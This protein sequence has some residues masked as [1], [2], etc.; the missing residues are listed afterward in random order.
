MAGRKYVRPYD[1]TEDNKAV[2]RDYLNELENETKHGFEQN[3]QCVV[4]GPSSALPKANRRCKTS[5]P[6]NDLFD[7]EE[8]ILS[9]GV[10]CIQFEI[11]TCEN[12]E[13]TPSPKCYQKLSFVVPSELTKLYMA[14]SSL[15]SEPSQYAWLRLFIKEIVECQEFGLTYDET[16][17]EHHDSAFAKSY[18]IVMLNDIFETDDWDARRRFLIS[19]YSKQRDACNVAF[20]AECINTWNRVSAIANDIDRGFHK[21][22][23]IITNLDPKKFEPMVY[24]GFYQICSNIST[25]WVSCCLD[26]SESFYESLSDFDYARVQLRKY[27][28]RFVT[29]FDILTYEQIGILD[30]VLA[31][32]VKKIHTTIEHVPV[33]KV[34]PNKRSR[35]SSS[36][37]S[38]ICASKR[39]RANQ[40]ES[41]EDSNE[42]DDSGE[43]SDY[44]DLT[45]LIVNNIGHQPS[46]SEGEEW[47]GVYGEL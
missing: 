16:E 3:L 23:S 24:E 33:A 25:R 22:L 36:S 12:N 10:Y 31:P 1:Y 47:M 9:S 26:T 32:S 18:N 6:Q 8:M 28:K 40:Y 4:S 37:S 5:P 42:S 35:D 19:E 30:F 46:S 45:D 43:D 38:D 15:E 20:Q 34:L 44:D 13:G 14:I 11:S 29:A 7:K 21:I 27:A 17:K 2:Y 39:S 41:D